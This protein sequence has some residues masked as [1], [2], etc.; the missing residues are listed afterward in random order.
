[1]DMKVQFIDQQ[2]HEDNNDIDFDQNIFDLIKK[3]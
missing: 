1:M 2:D 3:E